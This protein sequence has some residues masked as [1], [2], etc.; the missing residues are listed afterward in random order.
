MAKDQ[1][2]EVLG[3][4]S[5][6][7]LSLVL[8]HGKMYKRVLGNLVGKVLKI[9]F[10]IYRSKRSDAQN[11]YMWG[12]VVP[13]VKNW[14]LET[15]GEKKDP[16]EIYAWLNISILGNKPKIVNI[17][18]EDVIVMTGKR[19]SAMNT[20]EFAEAVDTIVKEMDA[21]GCYISLPEGDNFLHDHVTDY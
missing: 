9:K 4:L 13:T 6:D 19:F 2:F 15:H 7:R 14:Y 5:E 11:R 17:M 1:E 10:S 16:E 20:K 21:K 8:H 3:E 12:V 18:D